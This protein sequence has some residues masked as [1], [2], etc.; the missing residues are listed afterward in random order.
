M[1]QFEIISTHDKGA[2]DQIFDE[3]RHSDLPNERQAIK[4]SD[5]EPILN[6]LPHGE[7]NLDSQDRVMYHSIFSVAYPRD[8]EPK[9]TKTRRRE[10]KDRKAR[11]SRD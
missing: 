6:G 10:Q 7:L 9:E 1:N 8:D 4:F 2:R 11:E 3:L 5:V